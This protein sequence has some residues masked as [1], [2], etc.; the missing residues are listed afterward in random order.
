MINNVRIP[1]NTFIY[2]FV[3]F[4]PNRSI[5]AIE[6]IN[7]YPTNLKANYQDGSE[8][9]YIENSFRADAY[10]NILNV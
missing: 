7:H 6:N 5:I 9:I 8:G 2:G 1:R 4:R 3:S 10:H